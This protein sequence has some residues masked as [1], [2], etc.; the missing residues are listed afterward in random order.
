MQFSFHDVTLLG[1]THLHGCGVKPPNLMITFS[2]GIP[3]SM[4]IPVGWMG[5]SQLKQGIYGVREA[6]PAGFECGL[7]GVC[8]GRVGERLGRWLRCH[9]G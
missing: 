5:A 4:V 8:H 9:G 3:A 6:A 1:A 7:S 2:L